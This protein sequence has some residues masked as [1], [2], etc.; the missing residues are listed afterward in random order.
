[1]DALA[2]LK[3]GVTRERY[4]RAFR[5]RTMDSI[6]NVPILLTKAEQFLRL[7]EKGS[8][9]TN[10]FLRRIHNFALDMNWLPWPVIPKR[11]WPKVRFK[12]KRGVTA[13]EHSA[14]LAVEENPER[15]AFY[16]LCWH[17]GG[18]Q[19]DIARLCAEDINWEQNTISFLR[20][21]T[22][23]PSIVSIGPQLATLLRRLPAS[24]PFFPS[25]AAME[26]KHRAT[27]FK[28]C[29]RRAG[30]QGVTLH[31]YRYAWAERARSSGYPERFAQE[32][33]GHN[34]KAV[35]RHYARNAEVR[36]PSLEDYERD[37]TRKKVIA[38]EFGQPP[39]DQRDGQSPDVVPNLLSDVSGDSRVG[40]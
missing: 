6:R 7:L 36:L 38:L 21:K 4:L 32:A 30:V 24:G 20:D 1:M 34:S 22:G 33:L 14:L 2:K 19:S 31:S 39:S 9:A 8:V 18:A 29:C 26:A 16:R 15:N 13:E 23:A 28:R 11:Q 27:Q 3:T 35:H 5:A 17:L 25:V 40:T 37:T 12:E 10:V